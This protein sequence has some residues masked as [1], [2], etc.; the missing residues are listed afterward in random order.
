MGIEKLISMAVVLALLAVSTGQLPRIVH[1]SFQ[2]VGPIPVLDQK[3]RVHS[4]RL[5]RPWSL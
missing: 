2:A 1:A 4:N 3:D 5:L